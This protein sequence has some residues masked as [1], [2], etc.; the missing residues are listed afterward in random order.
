MHRFLILAVTAVVCV[1]PGAA[2]AQAIVVDHTSLPLFEQIPD[3]YLQAAR[4]LR[5]LFM[6]RSV[7]VNTHEALDCFTASSYGSSAVGCRRDYQFVDGAWQM[8]LR[9]DADLA[10]GRVDP[11]IRFNPS[12]TRYNRSNWHFFLFHGTWDQMTTD[13]ITGLRNRAVTASVHPTNTPVLIDPLDYDVVSFQ[14]SYL[15]VESGSTINDFFTR[16]PGDFSD[17]H[18]LEREV[19]SV[20]TAATPPRVFVYWTT[21]LARSIGTDEATQFNDRM[22]QWCRDNNKILFDFADIISHDMHGNECYDNRDG[23]Y[24]ETPSGN[25]WENHP[26]DGRDIPAVCQEKTTETDGGHLGTAQGLVSVAK[27]LWILHARIAG[28][29]PD[30]QSSSPL[31]PRNLRVT[32][33]P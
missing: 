7:G 17:V 26:D 3:Q 32:T 20:L 29:N 14:F 30:G 11:Y 16:R 4:D 22:R 1:L 25:R 9:F 13:F 27:G 23:V 18:D 5:V 21:S 10:A 24:Y 33:V 31:P 28:W 6:D 2:V 15:N 12:P 19:A 8:I